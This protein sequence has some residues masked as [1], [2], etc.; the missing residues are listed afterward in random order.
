VVG[1]GIV[2]AGG[3]D[4][5]ELLAWTGLRLRDV[6]DFQDLGTAEAGDLHSTHAAEAKG[7]TCDE[8][9]RFRGPLSLADAA[10]GAVRRGDRRRRVGSESPIAP[11][12]AL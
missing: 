1:V 9:Q 7:R 2:H 10:A 8:S 12:A 11:N 4:V 5:V 3:G 6:D